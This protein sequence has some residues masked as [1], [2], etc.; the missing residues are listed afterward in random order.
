MSQE[1]APENKK[2]ELINAIDDTQK[3]AEETVEMAQGFVEQGQYMADIAKATK[4]VIKELPDDSCLPKPE[5]DRQLE[6]WKHAQAR[7]DEAN[8]GI[9]NIYSGIYAP[10]MSITTSGISGMMLEMD[11]PL[12]L[13][14][15]TYAVEQLNKVIE[16]E[17]WVQKAEKELKR[18]VL[19]IPASGEKSALD[20]LLEAHQSY[21]RNAPPAAVLIPIRESINTAIAELLRRRPIQEQAK[22]KSDQI[23]SIAAQC[24]KNTVDQADLEAIAKEAERVI[25][26]LSSAKHDEMEREKVRSHFNRACTFLTGFLGMIDETK[27]RS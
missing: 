16:R 24:M 6:T 13:A 19:N 1:Q 23:L 2:E 9:T 17:P 15:Y 10:I 7:I 11:R 26:D 20:Q 3:A 22:N 5:R 12:A 25:D 27:L 18:L 8:R 14:G 4:R 21:Q